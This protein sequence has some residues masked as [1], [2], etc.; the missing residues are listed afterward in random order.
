MKDQPLLYGEKKNK[1]M[2]LSHSQTQT[3]P[4]VATPLLY[5]AYA[6]LSE[7]NRPE[8]VSWIVP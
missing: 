8:N 5:F 2:T 4:H 6:I 1:P 3:K 7:R